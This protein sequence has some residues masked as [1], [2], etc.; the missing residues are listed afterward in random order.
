M[1]AEVRPGTPG[2]VVEPVV[3]VEAAVAQELE[4]GAAKHVG[5]GPGLQAHDGAK[6]PAELRRI[7]A[8]LHLQLVQR[9]D[10]WEHGHRVDPHLVVVEAVEQ[11]VV[12]PIA[13]AVGR[14]RR[15]MAPRH[16]TG[17]VDVLAGH[18]AGDA[19]NRSRQLDEVAIAQRQRLDLFPGKRRAH[20]RG[21]PLDE[22]VVGGDDDRLADAARRERHVHPDLPVDGEVDARDRRRLEARGL[23]VE[24]VLACRQQRRDVIAVLVGG[25]RAGQPRRRVDE[26]DGGPWDDAAGRVADGSEDGAGDGLGGG[27]VGNGRKE[28]SRDGCG[29]PIRSNDV[30]RRAGP[31]TLVHDLP[32]GRGSIHPGFGTRQ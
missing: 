25:Q 5:A 23:G 1:K 4:S 9:L 22:R 8:G 2:T 26:R 17:A 3:G 24:Q 20:V 21:C 27:D 12:V 31:P 13:L 18:A 28:N 16:G 32:L 29:Q 6:R 30:R 7:D 11:E 10:A 19:G 14:E 15:G